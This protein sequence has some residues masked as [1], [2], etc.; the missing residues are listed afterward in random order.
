MINSGKTKDA[1]MG[2][3]LRNIWLCTA[4]QELELRAVH[5]AGEENRLADSL[6]RWHLD[7]EFYAAKFYEHCNQNTLFQTEV[8]EDDIFY[9][10]EY[11]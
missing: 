7:P 2:L 3:F 11:I 8:L 5:L 1:L 4:T 9:L 6:S 10:H